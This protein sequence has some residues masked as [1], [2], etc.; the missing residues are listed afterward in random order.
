MASENPSFRQQVVTNIKKLFI[1]IFAHAYQVQKQ[2]QLE[3]KPFVIDN[4]IQF[5]KWFVRF[6]FGQIYCDAPYCQ[7]SLT[8]EL[9]YLTALIL[10]E[11]NASVLVEQISFSSEELLDFTQI[12]L[13]CF[14]DTYDPNRSTVLAIFQNDPIFVVR[15][16]DLGILTLI[17]DA[18]RR[19]LSPQPDISSVAAYLISYA[20]LYQFDE[21]TQNSVVKCIKDSCK[22]ISDNDSY[23]YFGNAFNMSLSLLD[24]LMLL[25]KHQLSNVKKSILAATEGSPLFGVLN[26]IRLLCMHQNIDRNNQLVK[27]YALS[28]K[29]YLKDLVHVSLEV[30][31]CVSEY[32][33]VDAPEGYICDDASLAEIFN[34]LNLSQSEGEKVEVQAD[35]ARMLLVSCWRS[36][37]EISLLL[38]TIVSDFTLSTS[39]YTTTTDYLPKEL[40][41]NIWEM[42]C[43]ILLRSKHAGAY[44][45]ATVGFIKLCK[46]LWN[47]NHAALKKKPEAAVELLI[48]DLLSPEPFDYAQ[49]TRRSAGLPF[50]LKAICATE[51]AVCGKS[52]FTKLMISLIKICRNDTEYH[53]INKIII[54]LNILRAFFKDTSLSEDVTQYVSN[55]IM[56]AISGFSSS[57]WVVRNSATLLFSSLMQRVFGVKKVK[58]T[59]RE[60]FSKY[61]AL[62]DFL[63]E[64]AKE[65]TSDDNATTLHPSIFPVLLLLSHLYPSSVE[66]AQ[67]LMNLSDYIPYVT[68]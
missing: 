3:A 55:G 57:M 5:T 26:A 66:G 4:Y 53:D 63:L 11:N 24:C 6:L 56:I 36:L 25:L 27:Q 28:F 35:I 29:K 62:Y 60:F 14:C 64:Q 12:L 68:K 38:G 31:A 16:S 19:L 1:R 65:M 20:C 34:L 67:T 39:S 44:E 43:D 46:V 41:E 7:I 2:N 50:Y 13:T 48:Q 40:L 51:P 49:V 54:A 9:L 21:E 23:Q 61:P 22:I 33:S 37:K 59:G 42:F 52:T 58:C 8:L 30:V 17:E 32:V 10:K 15:L 47:S 18:C 45:L